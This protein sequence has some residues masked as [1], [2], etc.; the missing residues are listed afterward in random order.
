MGE[1][2]PSQVNSDINVVKTQTSDSPSAMVDENSTNSTSSSKNLNKQTSSIVST[3]PIIATQSESC[4]ECGS[5]TI[6]NEAC[7]DCFEKL[8]RCTL[9]VKSQAN[10]IAK[11]KA[12]L[13]SL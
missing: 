4:S 8:K 10:E 2:I 11:L 13:D 9:L 1:E 7:K 5:E 3:P 6:E 12:E